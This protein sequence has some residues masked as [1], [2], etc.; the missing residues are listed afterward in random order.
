MTIAQSETRRFDFGVQG[1][2]C[3]S[4]VAAVE[5]ALTALPG[6]SRASANL[7]AER[8]SV[9][10]DPA[11]VTPAA[12]VRA[13][14]EAGFV[15]G[16]EKVTIPVNGISCASC[17]ATIERALREAPGVVSATVNFAT[18]AATVEFAPATTTTTDLRQTIR[19]AGYEPL[20]V[21]DGASAVDHEKA[22]RIREV[23][24]LKRKLIAGVLTGQDSYAGLLRQVI[25]RVEAGAG[26]WVRSRLKAGLHAEGT[27][28]GN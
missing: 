25:R 17:V 20:E 22:A 16:V 5:R 27:G 18:N 9:Q 3:A 26:R 12:L 4:C 1:M 24:T 21:K 2:S 14:A 7:A 19:E 23:R 10:Y 11:A 28:G 6:V 13:V 15:P 8:G